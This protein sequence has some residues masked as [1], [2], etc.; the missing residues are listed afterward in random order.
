[1]NW[2]TKF[3]VRSLNAASRLVPSREPE[4]LLTGRR[5]EMEAYLHL[6]SFGLSHCGR[7]L[8]RAP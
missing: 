7:E 6:R 8:S 5:G 4:H 1:M 2:F 3:V